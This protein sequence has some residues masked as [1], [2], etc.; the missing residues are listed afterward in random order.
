VS[1]GTT[2]SLE[3]P[4]PE[5]DAVRSK[6]QRRVAAAPA[7]QVEVWAERVEVWAER[8]LSATS[9]AEVLAD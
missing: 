5:A 9:L 2:E 4:R 1:P 6:T 8:V 7:E 3:R